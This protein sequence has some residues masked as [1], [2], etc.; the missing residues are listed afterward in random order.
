MCFEGKEVEVTIRF[1]PKESWGTRGPISR[2]SIEDHCS[3]ILKRA[4]GSKMSL[5]EA[6]S[7][8]GTIQD[9]LSI[10]CNETSAVTSLNVKYEKGDLRPIK[11]YVP[12]RGQKAERK[13]K[14]TYPALNYN[15]IGRMNGVAKWLK[16][17]E[18]YSLPVRLLTSN[19][20]NDSAYNEDK[21]SRLFT[22]IEG[23]DSR[24]KGRTT[25]RMSADELAEFVEDAIPEFESITN[26]KA[27]EWAGKVKEIRDQRLSHADPSSKLMPDGREMHM[28]TNALYAAGTSF[29]LKEMGMGKDQIEEHIRGCRQS[30]LLTEQQ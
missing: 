19:W 4:D 13:E 8:T 22:A 26:R 10:C 24:K 17:S 30:M 29:L 12:M 27:K 11:T 16:T 1:S 5:D 6:L 23:M 7:V 9:L 28:M 20:Y 25:A 18:K 14:S 15:D 3:M 2:Y 21:L